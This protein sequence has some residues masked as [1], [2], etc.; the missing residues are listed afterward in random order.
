[1]MYFHGDGS[2]NDIR[3]LNNY[4]LN[5]PSLW[6]RYTLIVEFT[7]VI[8]FV[9]VIE[10]IIETKLNLLTIWIRE[11]I[12][13][14]CKPLYESRKKCSHFYY[15]LNKHKTFHLFGIRLQRFM[16]NLCK[17]HPTVIAF[18]V[19]NVLALKDIF[20]IFLLAVLVKFM[21]LFT[22]VS[23]NIKESVL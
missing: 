12:L 13:A 23:L 4:A 19:R 21:M 17:K 5:N 18:M 11:E 7:E 3:V 6:N 22:D 14:I 10:T 1:M 2:S 20:S 16:E 9:E 15:F 8:N